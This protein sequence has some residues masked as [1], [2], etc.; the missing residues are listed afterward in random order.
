MEV[1]SREE[2]DRSIDAEIDLV[3]V[4]NRNLQTFEMNVELSRELAPYIPNEFVKV[5]ESGIESPQAIVDL[6]KSGFQGFLIGQTFMAQSRPG[7]AARQFI[8][9]L[10]RIMDQTKL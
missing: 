1:H 2:L 9:E 7:E 4:N 3:G 6:R 8:T 10:N 5:S